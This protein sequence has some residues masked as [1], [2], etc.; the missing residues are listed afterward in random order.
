MR[1]ILKASVFAI[2][3]ASMP[4]TLSAQSTMPSDTP[5]ATEQAPSAYTPRPE[6]QSQMDTWPAEQ[7]S[8]Y[9][10][11]PAG[12]QE[13]FWTLDEEQQKGW[14]AL[15]S[16]Q[17]GQVLA[18]TPDQRTQ[19]WPSIV[20]QVNG[21]SA[22][23]APAAPANPAQPNA[24]PKTAGM[25]ENQMPENTAQPGTNGMMADAGSSATASPKDYPVCSKTV[26]DSCRNRSGV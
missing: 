19:I 10:A 20:A 24:G 25:A 7:K 2:A 11:W 16:E 23:A 21:Q 12:Q 13:Y 8:K 4:M 14:W 15:T 3:M 18:M 26:K 22:S 17:K 6:E 9:A 1:N 5:A